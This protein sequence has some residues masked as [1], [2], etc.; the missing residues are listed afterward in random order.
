MLEAA[1]GGVNARL[2]TPD[3]VCRTRQWPEGGAGLGSDDY[4]RRWPAA[5]VGRLSILNAALGRC[6]AAC[7]AGAAA[8]ARSRD[9]RLAARTHPLHR[10][11]GRAAH[12]DG[13]APRARPVEPQAPRADTG[14]RPRRPLPPPPPAPDP[15]ALAPPGPPRTPILK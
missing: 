10:S 4:E 1:A 2:S 14:C 7:C 15:A 12:G 5:T 6:R 13:L 8:P 3:R 11:R 9:E